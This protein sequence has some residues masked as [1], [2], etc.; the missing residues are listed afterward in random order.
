[1]TEHISFVIVSDCFKHD[2][3]GE[4]L[5]QNKLGSFLSSKSKDLTKI[6]YFPDGAA[7]KYKNRNNFINI[8]YHKDDFGE[9]TG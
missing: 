5:F 7:S 1:M 3:V 4:H 2:N 9:D 8:W 6:Y